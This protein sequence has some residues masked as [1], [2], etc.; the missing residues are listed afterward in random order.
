MLK[1]IFPLDKDNRSPPFS[2]MGICSH[3]LHHKWCPTN[4]PNSRHYRSAMV[5]L[6]KKNF[7][8]VDYEQLKKDLTQ[9][10]NPSHIVTHRYRILYDRPFV[11]YA[12]QQYQ[13]QQ[14][15]E[16]D[17]EMDCTKF[18]DNYDEEINATSYPIINLIP[19]PDDKSIN[20]PYIEE[21]PSKDIPSQDASHL[22]TAT[23]EE[24]PSK[25]VPSKDASHLDTETNEI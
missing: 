18:P 21:E 14:E 3:H 8:D 15:N 7:E 11:L 2:D 25:D 24:E 19:S 4:Y 23:V 16:R 13:Y 5:N 17:E 20:A 22:D 1:G 9:I 10:I 12:E 6:H